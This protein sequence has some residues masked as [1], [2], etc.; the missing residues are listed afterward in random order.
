MRIR[1]TILCVEE[2]PEILALRRVLLSIAG[3]TVLTASNG[4]SALE[5]LSGNYVDMVITDYVVPDLTWQEF[6]SEMK[7]R[8]PTV[9]ILVYTGCP[10]IPP[11]IAHADLVLAKG[12]DSSAL[13]EEIAK[14]VAK[15]QAPASEN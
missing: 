15:S 4:R 3:Y 6:A 10:R 13:L 7:R 1:F 5:I 14:L 9:P 2:N 11:S 12:M 8:E